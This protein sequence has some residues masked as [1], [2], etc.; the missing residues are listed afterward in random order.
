M[1]IISY[2]VNGIRAAI[3]KGFIDWLKTDPADIICLQE[4]KAHKGDIDVAA[5]EALGY[6]THWFCAQDRAR[7]LAALALAAPA[8][9]VAGAPLSAVMLRLHAFGMP[10]WRWMFILQGLPAIAFGVVTFYYMTDRPHQAGWLRPAE[11]EWLTA[12]LGQERDAKPPALRARWRQGLRDRNVL[13]LT[14]AHFCANLAGYGFIL[15]LPN[16]LYR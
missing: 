14:A 3:K 5:F 1:R 10:G 11:R 13:R 15:W 2:N 6:N 7:A 9:L 12:A 16:T 4:V 8:S